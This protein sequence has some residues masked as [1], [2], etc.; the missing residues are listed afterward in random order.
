MQP[1]LCDVVHAREQ[2]NPIDMV[3]CIMSAILNKLFSYWLG[4]YWCAGVLCDGVRACG[5]R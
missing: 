3:I 4:R 1:M 2:T 5:K